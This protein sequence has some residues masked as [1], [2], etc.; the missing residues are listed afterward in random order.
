[1]ARL[2]NPRDLEP[3]EPRDPTYPG[4]TP[5]TGVTPPP[6]GG[7]NP[8]TG[9]S[10]IPSWAWA[11]DTDGSGWRPL[12]G[13]YWVHNGTSRVYSPTGTFVNT[14]SA[15]LNS[16]GSGGTGQPTESNDNIYDR[17]V[18]KDGFW[19]DPLKDQYYDE[20]YQKMDKPVIGWPGEDTPPDPFG[21]SGKDE[22]GNVAPPAQPDV[23]ITDTDYIG[24][25]PPTGGP[26]G[27]NGG[28]PMPG[29]PT[30]GVRDVPQHLAVN[31]A[32]GTPVG[33]REAFKPW[34]KPL[35]Y[36][37]QALRYG[38]SP[39]LKKQG[40]YQHW[41]QPGI[42]WDNGVLK[43]GDKTWDALNGGWISPGSSQQTATAQAAAL[44][45]TS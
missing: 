25:P 8:S 18:R 33:Q 14:L 1:M 40:G 34:G 16:V 15:Y 32:S 28:N 45:G 11:L 4:Q 23:Q 17:F 36:L 19:Y 26:G 21:D 31:R 6:T 9:G 37:S 39:E 30:T 22:D 3:W 41:D 20:Q 7:S 43:W 44:R 13:G 10:S 2:E 27:G 24:L 35:G 38:G 5:G 42:E 29:M 12:E